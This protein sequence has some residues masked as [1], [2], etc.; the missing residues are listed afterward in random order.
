MMQKELQK[1]FNQLIKEIGNEVLELSVSKTMESAALTVKEQVPTL[2]KNIDQLK[3]ALDSLQ[4]VNSELTKN[5]QTSIKRNHELD[6]QLKKII[7]KIEEDT[8][9]V[10]KVE[11]DLSAFRVETK[12]QFHSQVEG[13]KKAENT[14]VNQGEKLEKQLS[15]LSEFTGEGISTG[16][17]TIKITKW[18]FVLSIGSFAMLLFLLLQSL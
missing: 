2:E 11:E 3:K 9:C 7:R 12:N 8:K 4:L 16:L 14:T 17:M 10:K 15:E 5:Y 13:L 6:L 18:T 1:E